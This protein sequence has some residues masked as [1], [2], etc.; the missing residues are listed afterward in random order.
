MAVSTLSN[1]FLL[2]PPISHSPSK[3]TFPLIINFPTRS[4]FR[5]QP[6][7]TTAFSSSDAAAAAAN[8]LP[9]Q[10]TIPIELSMI[11]NIFFFSIFYVYFI[12]LF[13]TYE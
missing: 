4:Q 1:T 11:C 6:P 3:P 9:Q 13:I 7:L 8:P 10:D 5:Q 2:S 12:Y